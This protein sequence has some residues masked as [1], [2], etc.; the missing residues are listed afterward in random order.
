MHFIII[1]FYSTIRYVNT[2]EGVGCR[3][4]G[5]HSAYNASLERIPF[6]NFATK[7]HRRGLRGAFKN[8]IFSIPI[9]FKKFL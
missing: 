5:R 6:L 4:G 2:T 3:L 1:A 7:I 8:K 9:I